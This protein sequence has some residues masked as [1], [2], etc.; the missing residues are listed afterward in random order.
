MSSIPE[1]GPVSTR[2]IDHLACMLESTV[3]LAGSEAGSG[4]LEQVRVDEIRHPASKVRRLGKCGLP[5]RVH[6]Q[7]QLR[8]KAKLARG[9]AQLGLEPQQRLVVLGSR[10]LGAQHLRERVLHVDPP[11]A[12]DDHVDQETEV[13]D[14]RRE[15]VHPDGVAMSRRDPAHPDLAEVIEARNLA[16]EDLV[17]THGCADLGWAA[18]EAVGFTFVDGVQRRALC[19]R[20]DHGRAERGGYQ[21]QPASGLRVHDLRLQDRHAQRSLRFSAEK[22]KAQQGRGDEHDHCSSAQ[23]EDTRSR[24]EGGVAVGLLAGRVAL[25]LEHPDDL[26]GALRA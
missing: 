25:H 20:A 15:E 22:A 11:H 3:R 7:V 26:D 9:P 5:G 1:S 19:K 12:R 14:R 2:G 16:D 10:K 13:V 4:Q 23:Y 8:G 6:R 17:G 24:P 21:Q 18:G